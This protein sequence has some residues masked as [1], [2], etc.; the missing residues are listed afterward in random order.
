MNTT[1]GGPAHAPRSE[2][3]RFFQRPF[4]ESSLGALI[5]ASAA[6]T[7]IETTSA[8]PLAW[9]VLAVH[10]IS[11][12]FVVELVLRFKI[13]PSR[14]GFFR[15]Y[16]LDLVSL[17]PLLA[18][19]DRLF[20]QGGDSLHAPTW[21]A[22]LALLRIFRLFRLLKI[23]RHR[24]LLFP[25]VIR[26]GAREVFFASGLVLLAIVFASSALV[27]FERDANPGMR[28][29]TQAFWFSVYS[30][31][32][33]EPIPGPPQTFGGHVVAVLVILTGLFT[34]A[35]V[36]GTI[37]GLVAERMRTGELI[38]DWEDLRDHLIVCGWNRKAEIIIREYVAAYPDDDLPV[39]VVAE[40]EGGVP[41]IRDAASRGRV[42]FLNDDFTKIEA[43]EKAGV[44][45]AARCILLAD[46]SK[47]RKERDADARTVLAALTIER[48]NPAVYTVAEIH[49]R[50]HAHHLEMG[51]VNDYVVSGEQSAFLLAQSAITRGV[52]SV[53]SELLTREHGNRFS[54][55]SVTKRWKGKS[56]VELLV[57][58]KKEHN[59]LLVG[60]AEGEKILIN[61]SDYAFKGD[62]DVVIIAAGDV[63][64]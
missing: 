15:E 34:F 59:A 64:L 12:I 23:A 5:L 7:V 43:L 29:F 61:P 57:H 45:R 10:G 32:A 62:E 6:L 13:A 33:A 26:R 14:R 36:V 47:A 22:A 40:L 58:M 19:V 25:R 35:T 20:P 60:V 42:Q 56:F 53:F 18:S 38:M 24:V 9:V 27:M 41:T 16:W 11:A 39:V 8:R 48:M 1:R 50:E 51:K 63:H 37:S 49:R 44:K 4:V 21:L 28:T 55:C 31:V 17:L 3:H 2:L 54:R 52:M 46:T 30:I